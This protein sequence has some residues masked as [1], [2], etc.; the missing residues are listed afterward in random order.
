MLL[1]PLIQELHD[2]HI[3]RAKF[4]KVCADE[5]ATPDEMYNRIA[6]EVAVKF[7]AGEVEFLYADT[8]MIKVWSL[9]LMDAEEFGDGFTLAEP[10][11]SIYEAFD[12]GEWDHGESGNPVEKYTRPWLNEILGGSASQ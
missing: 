9:M 8:V 3:E 5:G 2:T 11:F 6:T 12:A 10:A 7:L 4:D 1:D